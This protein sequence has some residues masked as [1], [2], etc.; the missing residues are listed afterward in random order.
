MSIRFRSCTSFSKHHLLEHATGMACRIYRL[1][2]WA[3]PNSEHM[4]RCKKDRR[5]AGQEAPKVSLFGRSPKLT[6]ESLHPSSFDIAFQIQVSS[7]SSRLWRDGEQL[8]EDIAR[9]KCC[10]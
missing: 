8:V 9:V 6:A 5:N 4:D 7:G 2:F 3:S 10:L 1:L